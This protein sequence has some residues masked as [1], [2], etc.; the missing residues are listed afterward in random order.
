MFEAN[1]IKSKEIHN[2][3]LETKEML[4][5]DLRA[6]LIQRDEIHY[7]VEQTGWCFT[8]LMSEF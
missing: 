8:S 7:K 1:K 5:E 3:K 4:K 6:T 2:E